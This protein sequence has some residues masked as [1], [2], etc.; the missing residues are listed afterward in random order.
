MPRRFSANALQWIQ[1]TGNAM[2]FVL[3]L[4]CKQSLLLGA[5]SNAQGG[6]RLHIAAYGFWRGRFERTYLDV[7]VFNSHAP[8][9][10]TSSSSLLSCYWKQ[11]SLKK[12]LS[13]SSLRAEDQESWTFLF[14]PPCPFWNRWY[15]KWRRDFL[16][17]ACLMPRGDIGPHI[18]L[19][20]FGCAAVWL[21]CTSAQPPS[22]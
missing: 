17:L 9:H 10:R 6:A 7:R 2:I 12:S 4:N 16:Q 22:A 18:P 20:C 15:G 11:E 14:H 19:P 8:S 5:T 1:R 3:N 21:S 13:H